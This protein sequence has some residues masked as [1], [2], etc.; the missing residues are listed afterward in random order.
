MSLREND[1]DL[2]RLKSKYAI[3][4]LFADGTVLNS[5]HLIFRLM[6]ESEG[7]AF[8][9]GVSVSKRNFK[10]AVDRNRIKRQLRV[11]LKTHEN[12][13]SFPGNGMLIFKAR[14]ALSTLAIIEET[15][16]LLE[17][18]NEWNSSQT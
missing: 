18:C 12:N 10:K 14:K 3:E 9:A 15:K 6:K 4:Q 1:I 5:K 16:S 2:K 11:A 13:L 8:Y 7:Q 17:N